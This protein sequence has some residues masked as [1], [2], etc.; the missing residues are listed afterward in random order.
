MI[1]APISGFL[2]F[3][4]DAV[5]T[6]DKIRAVYILRVVNENLEGATKEGADKMC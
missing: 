1:F 5:H 3:K 6:I 4:K 2:L